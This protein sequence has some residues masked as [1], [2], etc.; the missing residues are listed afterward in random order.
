MQQD[1]PGA[2]RC[3]VN[4]S[5]ARGER[6]MQDSLS[7][8]LLSLGLISVNGVSEPVNRIRNRGLIRHKVDMN[9]VSRNP[10]LTPVI[11]G[12]SAGRV[13]SGR[14]LIVATVALWVCAWGLLTAKALA[15][16]GGL[17]SASTLLRAVVA[18]VGCMLCLAIQR[19]LRW[20]RFRSFGGRVMMGAGLATAAAEALGWASFGLSKLF[21]QTTVVPGLGMTILILGFYAWVFFSWVTIYL[22]LSYSSE[23]AEAEHRAARASA[24]ATSAQLRALRYQLNPHFLFNT[25]NSLSALIL[26]QRTRDAEQMVVRLSTFLRTS[27]TTGGSGLITAE[28]EVDA[29]RRYLEIEQVRFPDLALRT[30]VASAAARGAVPPLILQPLVE[31]A[32]KFAIANNPEP[33]E[34]RVAADREGYWLL[35]TVSDSGT[36]HPKTSSGMG[37]GL[38]NIRDRLRTIYGQEASLLTEAK[39][40]GGFSACIKLPFEPLP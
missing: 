15:D 19:I 26:E 35:L 36:A 30:S 13:T 33:A 14:A 18:A 7:A 23:A 3:S 37:V 39:L 6:H 22:A 2:A 10:T 28:E 16:G 20:I 17:L 34:I 11:G 4:G 31:N 1:L 8:R 21:L 25:L 38:C 27:L 40:E 9:V 29:Q 32:I 5:D 12:G 24:E